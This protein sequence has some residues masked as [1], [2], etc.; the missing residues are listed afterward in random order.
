MQPRS[1]TP[2]D[3]RALIHLLGDDDP[4]VR[5]QARDRLRACG[6]MI[7]P[8]LARARRGDAERAVRAESDALLEEIR[9]DA[10][11][12]AWVRLQAAE[13]EEALVEGAFL[14]ERLI[15]PDRGLRQAV[16]RGE[17]AALA[18]GARTAVP[19]DGG[20]DQRVGALARYLHG[21][22]GFRGNLEAYG[23]PENSFLSSVLARRT[24]IPITLALVYR[25]V[26][27][28]AGVPLVGIGMPKRFLVGTG[29]GTGARY[30]DPFAGG[31]EVD[32]AE[33][34]WM[35][36]RAGL[37]PAEAYL[38]PAPVVGILERMARN[39]VVVYRGRREARLA[40]RFVTIL[41]GGPA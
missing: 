20:P 24:G 32:R 35:L 3:V 33:C 28:A 25:A 34:V 8:F 5:G 2:G 36:E 21:R 38:R 41:T 29:E 10:I 16:A 4:W 37:E 11:E 14:L 40:R 31:R 12:R 7:A 22:C 6:E 39:L 17:L 13:E 19:P 9:V 1:L 30:F 18:D 27:R 23:D 26:G 15:H